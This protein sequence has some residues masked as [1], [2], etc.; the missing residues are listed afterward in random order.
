MPL[1]PRKLEIG[2][3]SSHSLT[4]CFLIDLGILKFKNY[5]SYLL[6]PKWLRICILIKTLIGKTK[7]DA[8]TTSP[9]IW[10]MTTSWS[11]ILK[12]EKWNYWKFIDEISRRTW[13]GVQSFGDNK[14]IR[15]DYRLIKV[16]GLN[17]Q[18]LK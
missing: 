4:K 9:D 6:S 12:I 11:S 7:K 14:L 2:E 13:C 15:R 3:H 8:R 5:N 1:K 18:A 17:T 10:R 16:K